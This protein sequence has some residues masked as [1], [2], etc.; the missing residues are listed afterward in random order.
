MCA[1]CPPVPE[2]VSQGLDVGQDGGEELD[3]AHPVVRHEIVQEGAKVELPVLG[4]RELLEP[5]PI[6]GQL[7][8]LL[9]VDPLGELQVRGPRGGLV[10]RADVLLA[11][12]PRPLTWLAAALDSAKDPHV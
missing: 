10:Q 8:E 7:V 3:L 1:H 4:S 5:L 9:P 11:S 2:V 6:S 12:L